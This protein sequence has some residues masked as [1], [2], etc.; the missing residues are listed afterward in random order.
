MLK[1]RPSVVLTLLAVLVLLTSLAACGQET[2]PA[3]SPK[4]SPT[5]SPASVTTPKTTPAPTSAAPKTTAQ[6][7]APF[8]FQGK[9]VTIIVPVAAGGASDIIARVYSRYLP[10]FLPGNPN[11]IVRSMPGAGGTIGANYVNRAKPD[12]LTAL[13]AGGSPMMSDLF[14][15][16]AADYELVKMPA[17]IGFNAGSMAYA[18]GGLVSK[19]ED[20]PNAK[21]IIFG[22]NPAT[23]GYMFLAAKELLPIST[24]RLTF[25]YSGGA[26][27]R[28]AFLIGEINTGTTTYSAYVETIAPLEAKG[29][30]MLLFQFGI[31]DEKGDLVRGAGMPPI[32]TFKEL[33][34]KVN[35]KPPSGAAWDAYKALV[36]VGVN[37]DKVLLL[38][39]STPENV[40]KAYWTACEAMVKDAEFKKVAEPLVGV[41]GKWGVGPAYDK[42]FKQNFKMDSKAIDWLKDTLKKYGVVL[43]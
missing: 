35:G 8:S 43:E 13:A 25:A 27:H 32:Y 40:V 41:V 16:K 42:E 17:V 1:R 3:P 39:P 29:E 11:V 37:Y 36:A 19:P 33:Y 9:T 12:G 30:A 14:D 6:A 26:E 5:T 23:D 34:E 38:P 10:K 31:L 20:L 15:L 21:G 7:S 24:E 28:R 2:A 4:T 18:K 22:S